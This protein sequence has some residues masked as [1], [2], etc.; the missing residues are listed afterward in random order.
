MP[1]PREYMPTPK[2]QMQRRGS[3]WGEPIE[4]P[5]DESAEE[6]CKELAKSHG[7]NLTD[8]IYQYDDRYD[9]IYD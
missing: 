2:E 5:D 6:T 4:A 8:V 1:E 7:V 3:P 9:C